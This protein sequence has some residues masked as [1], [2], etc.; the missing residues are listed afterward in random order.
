MKIKNNYDFSN[1]ADP[2]SLYEFDKVDYFETIFKEAKFTENEK[3][4]YKMRVCS[5]FSYSRISYVMNISQYEA[6][7][8]YK[9]AENKIKKWRESRKICRQND[10]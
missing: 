4:V 1:Y 8:Y 2:K 6:Y 5:N 3:I 7:T 9:R 10:Y